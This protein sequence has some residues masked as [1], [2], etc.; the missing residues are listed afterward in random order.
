MFKLTPVASVVVC[1]K[2]VPLLL[3]I[4]L[5]NEFNF[6][7]VNGIM[8]TL[9]LLPSPK[10]FTLTLQETPIIHDSV[11]IPKTEFIANFFILL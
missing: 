6:R 10:G 1:S 3:L 4:Y 7:N 2:E 5:R 9:G 11:N 8:N